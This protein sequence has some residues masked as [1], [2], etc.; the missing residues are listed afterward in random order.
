V[1]LFYSKNRADLHESK[2]P[3]ILEKIENHLWENVPVYKNGMTFLE[4]II[5]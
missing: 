3:Q 4:I 1:P 2:L 5:L